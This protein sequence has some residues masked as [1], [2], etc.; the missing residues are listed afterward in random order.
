MLKNN[1]AKAIDLE[2][3]NYESDFFNSRH[4][5][6][7]YNFLKSLRKEP[8]GLSQVKCYKDVANRDAKNASHVKKKFRPI[9]IGSVDFNCNA[10]RKLEQSEN[11]G[12]IS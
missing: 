2:Q 6:I 12:R 10:Y 5:Q 7:E 4:F 1:L 11:N 3:K 9:L 8:L